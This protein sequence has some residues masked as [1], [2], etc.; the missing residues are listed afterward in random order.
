MNML[1]P[2]NPLRL[3]IGLRRKCT[4]KFGLFLDTS[5]CQHVGQP[6]HP[7]GD[8]A[9]NTSMVMS[10]SHTH[11]ESDPANFGSDRSDS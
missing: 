4:V 3:T 5:A 1:L 8:V 11:R 6:F 2:A 7:T 9:E 10:L